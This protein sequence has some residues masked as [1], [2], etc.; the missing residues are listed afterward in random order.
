MK[1]SYNWIGDFIDGLDL[2]AAEL[3][4]VI[5]LRTAE[6]EGVEPFGTLL[7]GAIIARVE[8]V[9][10]IEGSK[11]VKAIVDAGQYGLKTVVCGAPNC[12]PEIGRAHV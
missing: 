3:E 11:N 2:S 6:C 4:R 1:F 5:T 10:R 12:R 7:A 9:E 8:A